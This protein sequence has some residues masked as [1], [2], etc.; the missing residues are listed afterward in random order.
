MNDKI[1]FFDTET[2]VKSP[3]D[4]LLQLCYKLE[5][6]QPM[7][8]LFN[9][10]RQISFEAMA[11]HHIT[12]AMVKDKMPF[13][14]SVMAVELGNYAQD[15]LF[16]AHNAEFDAQMLKNDGIGI[17]F[18][19]DTLKVAKRLYPDENMYKLQYL[20]YRF[21]LEAGNVKAHDAEG[22]VIVLQALFNY[23]KQE[24]QNR[25]MLDP[26]AEML[27]FT[28]EPVLMNRLPF[29][30]YKMLTFESVAKEDRGYLEWLDGQKDI[31]RDLRFTL[32]KYL[33]PQKQAEL[34]TIR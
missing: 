11:T 25:N 17:K 4:K 24:C 21:G 29:G 6:S 12:E 5:D 22:D 34:P 19:I 8:S 7:T 26:I 27:I 28:R 23:L 16:V 3:E 1:L 32:D 14:D 18:Y 2:T 33:R 20:R 10:G 31:D 15:H 13:K 9:P 30:K